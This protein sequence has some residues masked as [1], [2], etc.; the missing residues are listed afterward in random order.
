VLQ[1]ACVTTCSVFVTIFCHLCSCFGQSSILFA[2][3]RS[4]GSQIEGEEESSIDAVAK[5]AIVKGGNKVSQTDGMK[6]KEPPIMAVVLQPAR[7][8]FW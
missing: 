1:H 5:G 6:R 4:K 7:V 2:V 8:S 3:F